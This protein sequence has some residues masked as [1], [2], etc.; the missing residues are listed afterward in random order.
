MCNTRSSDD[1]KSLGFAP[2]VLHILQDQEDLM[3]ARQDVCGLILQEFI[4][5]YVRFFQ[6]SA[7]NKY[8]Y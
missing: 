7:P 4:F 8:N 5:P 1:Q 6:S 3:K 2:L